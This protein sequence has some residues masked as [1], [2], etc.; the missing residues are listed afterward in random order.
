V[1]KTWFIFGFQR[2]RMR[3]QANKW[4]GTRRRTRKRIRSRNDLKYWA[5][6]RNSLEN[7][8]RKGTAIYQGLETRKWLKE[9]KVSK[10]LKRKTI[11]EIKL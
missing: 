3:T 11:S 10:D 4:I 5:E 1:L 7:Q 9:S 6:Q 8:T 2:L